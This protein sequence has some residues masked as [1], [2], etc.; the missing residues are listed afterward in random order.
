MRRAK[1]RS[2]VFAALLCAVLLFMSC[3]QDAV[4]LAAPASVSQSAAAPSGA[5]D[6]SLPPYSEPGESPGTLPDEGGGYTEKDDVAAYLAAYGRLPQNFITKR[7]AEAAGWDSRE[8]NLDDV[9]PGMSIG[10]DRFGNYYGQLPTKKGRKYHECDIGY[11][12]GD[13]GATRIISSNDGLI[14]YTDDHYETFTQ[15]YP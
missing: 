4:S 7:D 3:A 13:R 9:L 10:G 12:G 8:G 2:G 11:T 14:F 1:R 15:L 5:P 6:E